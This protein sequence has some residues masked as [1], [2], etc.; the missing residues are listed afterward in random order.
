MAAVVALS[1]R[2]RLPATAL[3]GACLQVS[4]GVSEREKAGKSRRLPGADG[5]VERL[6]K[7][8]A[9]PQGEG[10]PPPTGAVLWFGLEHPCQLSFCASPQLELGQGQ[11]FTAKVAGEFRKGT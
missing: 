4:P 10:G 2:G 3:G 9:R 11:F 5:P 8:R 6:R 7:H 1:L